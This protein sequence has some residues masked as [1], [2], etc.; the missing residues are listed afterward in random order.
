MK[1]VTFKIPAWKEDVLSFVN[2]WIVYKDKTYSIQIAEDMWLIK[3]HNMTYYR[4]HWLITT[5]DVFWK[6]CICW[7]DLIAWIEGKKK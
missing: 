6:V 4:K 5:K 1:K 7:T 2:A 3:K